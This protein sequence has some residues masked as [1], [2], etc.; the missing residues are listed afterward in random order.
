MLKVG[1]V[2]HTWNPAPRKVR[3][4]MPASVTRDPILFKKKKAKMLR[5]LI[6]K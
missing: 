3:T 6:Y 4:L 2:E 1:G 5:H